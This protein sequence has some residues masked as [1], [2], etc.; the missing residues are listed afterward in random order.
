M[1]TSMPRATRPTGQPEDVGL[2]LGAPERGL[3]DLEVG[4]LAH[5]PASGR[6]AVAAA[7]PSSSAVRGDRRLDRL[8]A[9]HEDHLALVAL[10]GPHADVA[11]HEPGRRARVPVRRRAERGGQP[12]DPMDGEPTAHDP[13]DHAAS[14]QQLGTAVLGRPPVH[15]S[16]ARD[17]TEARRTWQGHETAR[18]P[19]HGQCAARRSARLRPVGGRPVRSALASMRPTAPARTG[20]RASGTARSPSS[21]TGGRRPAAR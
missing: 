9:G 14:P 10:E 15:P 19:A 17:C 11:A 12:L 18:A 13:Q 21:A 4:D 16:P 1:S 2:G 3:V 6:R 8:P 5:G 20:R 7:T